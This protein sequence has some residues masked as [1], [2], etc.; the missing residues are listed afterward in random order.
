MAGRSVRRRV[1]VDDLVQE[2]FVRALT[3]SAGLPADELELWRLLT[4]LARH[5][6]IDCARAIRAQRRDGRV[7]RLSRAEWSASGVHESQIAARTA[8]ASTRAAQ[9][10]EAA[11]LRFAFEQLAPEHRRV[12][13]LRQFEGLSAR[14]TALRMGRSETAVH[15]LYRRALEAWEALTSQR[16]TG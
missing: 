7:V 1:E 2:T 12:L 9:A 16:D 11:R 3:R 6:V 5:A 10:D 15:S 4:V 14:E 8:G 13:G